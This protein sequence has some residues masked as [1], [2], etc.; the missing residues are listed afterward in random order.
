[1]NRN[2]RCEGSG[3]DATPVRAAY[4]YK[5]SLVN[6]DKFDKLAHSLGVAHP[7]LRVEMVPDPNG[8]E[9]MCMLCGGSMDDDGPMREHLR[10]DGDL[11]LR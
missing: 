7:D 9:L 1:M 11:T 3:Q 4:F 8:D 5:G 2:T 10:A 6:E